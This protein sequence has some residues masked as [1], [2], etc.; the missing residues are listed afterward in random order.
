MLT[1]INVLIAHFLCILLVATLTGCYIDADDDNDNID[2]EP[3]AI[4]RGVRTITG[5]EYVRI[6]WYPNAEFDLEGYTVWR[7]ENN[8]D[9]EAISDLPPG[10]SHYTD[11]DVRNGRTYYYAV[12]A[13][14]ITGN[15]S[16]LSPENAW[17]TPRPEG[18]NVTLDDFQ[19]A[20]DRSG[21]DFSHPR[22]GSTAWD[23][24]TTDVYFGLDTEV[25]ITYLYS[26]NETAMQDL[27][28]QEDFD[29]VDVV[30]EYGY[31]T[32]FVELIE[33]H[34]YA[35][36][37]PDGNFAKIHVRKLFD[38]AVVFDWAYQTDPENIQL[39]PALPVK[40]K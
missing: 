40:Q 4:P 25:N 28:Y 12:S 9:F 33:G 7:S 36:Y 24:R 30:P 17:D 20:P 3:P 18:R 16:E 34:I 13:Y 27:G 10:T 14:D 21:F 6:E 35:I 1:K 39:A 19:L 22:K 15:E 31:T 8:N 26:D 11:R 32:L 37:T 2:R 5:D 38:D 23:D 29:G